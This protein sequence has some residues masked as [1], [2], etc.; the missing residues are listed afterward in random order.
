MTSSATPSRPALALRI[1][2]TGTRSLEPDQVSRLSVQIHSVLQAAR[3]RMS[4]L[5]ADHAGV[6]AAY[7]HALGTVPQ[8]ALRFI[9]PLARGADRLGAQQAVALGYRLHVPMPFPKDEYEKDFD[10][11][12]DLAE[13][14]ALLARADEDWLALDGDRAQDMNRGYEAVGRYVVRHSDILIAIWDGSASRGRGG[15]ADIVRYAAHSGIP[16]CW[17]HATQ[18]CPAVWITDIQDLHH[19]VPADKP[20]E[21]ALEGYLDLII[22]PPAPC[23]R[24]R[25]G[26]VGWIARIGQSRDFSPEQEYF[27]NRARPQ[28]RCWRAYATLI[29]WTSGCKLPWSAPRRPDDATARHWFDRYVAADSRAANHAA[30]YRS[31]YVW[32]ILFGTLALTFGA[33]A[34]VLSLPQPTADWVKHLLHAITLVCA[35][36]EFLALLAIVSV[37]WLGTRRDWHERSIEYRLLAELCRKQQALAPLGWSLPITAVRGMATTDRPRTDRAAWVAWLFAA[38]SRSAPLPRG[39]LAHAAQGAPR[40]LVLTELI[41]EQREY[42]EARCIMAEKAGHSLERWGETL[43]LAVVICVLLKVGLTGFTDAHDW[44]VAFSFLATILPGI[45]A[46]FVAIRGYAELQLLAEQSRHMAAELKRA[47]WRVERLD[48][49]QPLASQDLGGEAAAVA[50]LMLQDLDGWARLFRVKGM[51]AA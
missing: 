19:P 1:G 27:S 22:P 2:I 35:G 42:H 12:D 10:T 24:S 36:A 49:T 8:P 9:S 45:S 4:E 28:R 18:D 23:T 14:H 47:Q 37:V 32:I 51:E 41:T 21:T 39:D 11:P 43:F 15:T 46:A 20:A 3:R 29:R 44:A 26:I 34:L 25:H 48:M 16:V 7:H 17:L 40:G 50:T 6:G 13:F 30:R 33:S 31:S 38:E 5:A